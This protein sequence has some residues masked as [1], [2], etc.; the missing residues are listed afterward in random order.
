VAG[1]GLGES[2]FLRGFA[3]IAVPRQRIYESQLIEVQGVNMHGSHDTHAP[4]RLYKGGAP[5]LW[6]LRFLPASMKT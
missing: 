1:R 3:K 6:S 2:D 5:G 4:A